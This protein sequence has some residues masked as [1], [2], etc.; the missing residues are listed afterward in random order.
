MLLT[1]L[2]HQNI[3]QGANDDDTTQTDKA[4]MSN[5]NNNNKYYTHNDYARALLA[6]IKKIHTHTNKGKIWTD[7][8]RTMKNNVHRTPNNFYYDLVII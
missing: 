3:K 8:T 1:A 4:N 7:D 6:H 2:H 5:N